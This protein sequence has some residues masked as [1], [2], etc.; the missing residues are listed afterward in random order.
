[1]H[2]QIMLRYGKLCRIFV[3]WLMIVLKVEAGEHHIETP[4]KPNIVLIVTDDQDVTM[5]GM[6]C[7]FIDL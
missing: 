2:K 4:P 5:G 6:V 1:M 3:V 7:L